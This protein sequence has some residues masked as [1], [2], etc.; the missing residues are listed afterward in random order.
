[1]EPKRIQ[2]EKILADADETTRKVVIEL[3]KLEQEV[4]YMSQPYGIVDDVV[5]RIKEVVK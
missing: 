4:L 1:V 5:S 2:I 3:F